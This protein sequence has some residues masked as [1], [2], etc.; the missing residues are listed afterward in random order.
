MSL[1]K[2]SRLS[3]VIILGMTAM[4]IPANAT[5]MVNI[6]GSI[7]GGTV[8][9]GTTFTDN[10]AGVDSNPALGVLDIG[11]FLNTVAIQ[12]TIN[13]FAATSGSP[14]ASLAMTAN[15]NVLSS[16]VLPVTVDVFITDTGFS[17]PPT[18]LQLDQTVNLLSSVRGVDASA[19]GKG[20]YGDSNTEFDVDGPSTDN[21]TAGVKNGIAINVPGSSS[22][23][24]GPTPYSLTSRIQ[25][26]IAARGS[27][28]IQN[29]QLNAN[30]SA[31]GQVPPQ[32]PEP[33]TTLLL[34]GSLLALGAMFR[35]RKS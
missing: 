5:L 21:A 33:N 25:L 34:G 18:P 30:L 12:F 2:L 6:G 27:D 26:T 9:G 1:Q 11:A 31:P 32:I 19:T 23:I 10:Q 24:N 7:L 20:W 14:I 3:A 17:N 29:I 15:A 22:T 13:G 35:M 8:V 16:T 28:P 4:T